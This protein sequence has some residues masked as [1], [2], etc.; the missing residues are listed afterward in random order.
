MYDCVYLLFYYCNAN[1]V[2]MNKTV[3][4][5]L[6]GKL[7]NETLSFSNW[8]VSVQIDANSPDNTGVWWLRYTCFRFHSFNEFHTC[9]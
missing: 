8:Q 9:S 6:V 2:G 1:I 5:S 7:L 3:I 4:V